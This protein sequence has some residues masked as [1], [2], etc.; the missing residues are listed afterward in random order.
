MANRTSRLTGS[1]PM[2][3]VNRIKDRIPT[4]GLVAEL[5]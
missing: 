1:E 2:N 5:A 3:I 4:V